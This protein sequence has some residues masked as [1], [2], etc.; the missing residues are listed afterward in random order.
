VAWISD[1]L[2]CCSHDK[3]ARDQHHI[4][5]KVHVDQ[6]VADRGYQGTGAISPAK[7]P[8]GGQLTKSDHQRNTSLN[9]IRWAIEAANVHIKTW[10]ILHS[11]YRRSFRTHTQA[12]RAIRALIFVTQAFE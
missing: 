1:P 12:F 7:T 11:D 3:A 6:V 2:A 4:A 10:R 8:V 5:G 9:K